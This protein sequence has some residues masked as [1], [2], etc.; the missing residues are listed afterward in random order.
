MST[1]PAESRTTGAGGPTHD[2][3]DDTPRLSRSLGLVDIV[4]FG[5]GSIV[6]AGIYAI[7]GEAAAYGGNVL[8][9]SFLLA[10]IVAF[11]TAAGYAE[12]VSRYPDA[13]GSFEY[14]KQAF[15]LRAATFASIFMLFTGVVAAGAIAISFSSYLSRL[16]GVPEILTTIAIVA[17]MGGVNVLGAAQASW[18]NGIATAVTLLGLAAVV[19]VAAPDMGSVDLLDADGAQPLSIGIG[20]ALIFFSFIG[21]EDL[22]KMAEETKEPE[23]TMPRG[24]LIST[25]IVLVV[26][27]VVAVA[28]VAALGPDQLADS[29]GP[30]AEIM[31][32]KAGSAWASAIVAVALFATSKT[33][34]SNLLGTSRLLYDVA[35]DAG[36][37]WL[38]RLTKI[39]DRTNTPVAAIVAVTIV[40]MG[41]GAVGNLRVVA[42]VSNILIMC[43]FLA[44][45]ASLLRLRRMAVDTAPFQLKGS[46]A[47]LP[48][49]TLLAVAGLLVLLG[50]NVASLLGVS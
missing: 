1:A 11:L 19:A 44:V 6:G 5:V 48:I 30:L 40:A 20:A 45:N 31:D 41:F 7:I 10:A 34:L 17:I 12:L 50:L 23:T 26:Y 38:Q 49:V 33:I 39:N 27:L 42:S 22:V 15:G 24:I 28:A 4:L 14:V 37:G 16:I 25:A 2:Q 9:L 3:A 8:W 35:R 13:G 18:F 46:V 29:P 36:M 47:G 43:V 21:F 32:S